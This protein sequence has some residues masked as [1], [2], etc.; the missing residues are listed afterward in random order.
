[1]SYDILVRNVGDGFV[2]F[3]AH[4]RETI[5]LE[6]RR[7]YLATKCPVQNY[8][9]FL[10]RKGVHV[11]VLNIHEDIEEPVKAPEGKSLEEELKELTE[12]NTTPEEEVEDN[13]EGVEDDEN[14]EDE[15]DPREFYQEKTKPELITILRGLNISFQPSLGKEKLIDLIM[16]NINEQ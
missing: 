10:I 11:S 14:I 8:Y 9:N 1:M 16:D 6:P 3:T 13:A 5:T 12:E 4:N 2:S 7:H 15:V